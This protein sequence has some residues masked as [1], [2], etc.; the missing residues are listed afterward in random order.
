MEEFY[1]QKK[2]IA[3]AI[4]AAVSAPAFADNSNV[5][6]YGQANMSYDMTNN[7]AI[8]TNK[9]SSNTS[10][11]GLKGSEDLGSGL[12]AV[13]Q[14]EQQINIDNST[15]NANSFATRN[16]FL[17]LSSGSMGTFILGRHDTPYKIATRGFDV[18]GDSIADNRSLMGGNSLVTWGAG[19]A[20]TAAATPAGASAGAS[21][22]GR[23]GDVVAYISPAMAG[24]TGAIA[25]VAG[26]E[27][28]T[29]AGQTKG[30]AWSLAG[31]YGNGPL[32]ANLGYEVHDLG[33]AVGTIGGPAVAGLPSLKESAWKLGVGYTM[34]A[35][36]VNAVYERT[37]DN[38]GALANALYAT[39]FAANAD[40][41]GHNAWYLSGKYSFGNDAVKLAYTKTGNMNA[42][43]GAD[44]GA[45]QVSVGYDHNLGKRT[46]L[47]GLYTRL[48]NGTNAQFGLSTAGSTGGMTASAAGVS[49]S[50]WSF[51]M[52]HTF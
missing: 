44:T 19:A 3:L 51:G 17:G 39:A 7:G 30:S 35:L 22:D 23:Q 21:F 2:F 38:F 52:K 13:W 34:D 46:T 33:T 5:T 24:F 29:T 45:K 40:V 41:F 25:Y 31:L 12:S 18:F 1:M 27:G 14:I 36:T 16:S 28:A 37:S 47:F 10:R 8:G 50:A 20:L 4:A 26:A 9:V 11:V 32:S 6:L 49:V 48:N 43:L 42:G 15:T